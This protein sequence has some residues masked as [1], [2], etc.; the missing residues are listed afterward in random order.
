MGCPG[1][2]VSGTEAGGERGCRCD[3]SS[4]QS[5][6]RDR[7]WEVLQQAGPWVM[8][9]WGTG[10]TR[11]TETTVRDAVLQV[12]GHSEHEVPRAK[13]APLPLWETPSGWMKKPPAVEWRGCRGDAGSTPR[14]RACSKTSHCK[15]L[16]LSKT[17]SSY[18]NIY[19][20]EYAEK[21]PE[22]YTP[23]F[24]QRNT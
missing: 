10:R 15:T 5:L 16:K 8:A 11:W 7:V 14:R 6:Q 3:P 21:G 23:V 4:L 24:H 1:A 13:E 17:L 12:P 18:I 9:L 2:G 20:C 19:T 22:N